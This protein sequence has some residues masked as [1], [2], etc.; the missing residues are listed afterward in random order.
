MW[1]FERGIHPC[2]RINIF[3]IDNNKL[4]DIVKFKHNSCHG[5]S[6][7]FLNA[8]APGRY[9]QNE[10]IALTRDPGFFHGSFTL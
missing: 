9:L 1:S 5:S 8:P 4:Y 7:E 6:V 2:D 3:Y 10:S